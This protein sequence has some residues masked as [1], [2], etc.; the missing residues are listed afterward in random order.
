VRFADDE[1]MLSNP[2]KWLQTLMSLLNDVTEEY[3]MEIKTKKQKLW[4]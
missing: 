1:A 2:A 3:R 4:L